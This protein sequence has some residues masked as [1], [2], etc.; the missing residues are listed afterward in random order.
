MALCAGLTN[1]GAAGAGGVTVNVALR[2]LPPDEPE[3]L[4]GVEDVTAVVVTVNVLLV[5]PAATVTLVGTVAAAELS[6]RVTTVP[7]EGAAAASVTVPVDEAPPATL[8]GLS[9]SADRVGAAAARVMD[10]AAN[11]NTLSS[12]A[13]NCTV[14]ESTGKVVTVKVALVAPAGTVTVAG[15]VAA[16]GRFAPRL[17]VTPPAGAP[18]DR[19]TVPVVEAPPVTL[20]GFTVK[21]V[22]VG[23]AGYTDKLL[24]TVTP[25]PETE[26]AT[27]VGAATRVVAM[28]KRPSS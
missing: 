2:V 13:L 6:E 15:T 24:E 7:P 16:P 17:T 11:W 9:V 1:A 14:V 25:P 3:M 8:D 23:R 19:V 21:E 4:I 12:A 22:N 18:P 5:A 27:V 26:K 20:V 10:S 28:S